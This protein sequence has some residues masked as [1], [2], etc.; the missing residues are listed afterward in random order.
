MKKYFIT[1]FVFAFLLAIFQPAKA[2]ET[3]NPNYIISDE[4]ILNYHAMTLDEVRSFL[5]S[6]G[7]YLA[8]YSCPDP[9]GK[10]MTAAEII[11]DR[12]INNRVSQRFIIVLLQKEQGLIEKT[13]PSSGNLDWATGY[14]C[15]DSG[16]CNSRW[17]GFW[18][19]VNSASLQFRD[20]MDNPHLYTYKAGG[21]Y[22]FTNPYSSFG[23]ESVTVSPV[24]QA[25]ASLYNYTPHVYNG[26]YNFFKLWQKYFARNTYPD[27]SLLQAKGEATVWLIQNNKKRPFLALNALTSRFD[28][29]KIISVEKADLDK[30]ETGIAIK[31]PQYSVVEAPD[32]TKY[33]LVDDKKRLIANNAVFRK[34]GFSL[35]EVEP[36]TWD[37]INVYADGLPLTST[38]TY[39]TGALLQ[40][41]TKG[42][43][44]WVNENQKAPLWDKI[45]LTTRFK[46]QK[47]IKVASKTL[48]AYPTTGPVKFEDGELLKANNEI[49]VYL[50]ANGE[51]HPFNSGET[52]EKLGYKWTNIIT[53]S[54]KVLAM[55]PLG[56]P[57]TLNQ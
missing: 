46:G 37:E 5:I 15:P 21:L 30:Y 51:K 2:Q 4:E 26:N 11:Y 3:F 14:G 35:E 12:A 56:T 36:A 44:Y 1:F 23:A 25:T 27:G 57:I 9:N 13:N 45:F 28:E 33:L 38:S 52:F 55:Y 53:V 18:K 47:I 34:I 29:A 17:Q 42:G 50:I 41:K 54:S 7:G 40:D 19:Q 8:N 43:V 32:S 6:K 31:F 10:M 48:D 49:G 16:G 22:V 39:A 24:N 20:Y